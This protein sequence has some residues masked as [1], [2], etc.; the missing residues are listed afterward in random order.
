MPAMFPRL[1]LGTSG[2][3]WGSGSTIAVVV[4]VLIVLGALF[5]GTADFRESF[6]SNFLANVAG[7]A[8]GVPIAI[9][10]SFQ[11]NSNQADA[12]RTR[13]A[14]SRPATTRG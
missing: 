12:A 4:A 1:R 14:N 5:L 9:W 13:E 11:E 2:S 10:L 8:L 7:V 6:G 3:G